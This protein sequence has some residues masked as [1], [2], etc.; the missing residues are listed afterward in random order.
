MKR[1]PTITASLIT[2][3]F[4]YFALKPGAFNMI[5]YAIYINII[6]QNSEASIKYE[7]AFIYSF[8]IVCGILLFW[9]I[10]KL[11]KRVVS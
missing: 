4:I 9:I 2:A 8:D 10:Y 11:T 3:L 6:P 7:K 5:G 1:I